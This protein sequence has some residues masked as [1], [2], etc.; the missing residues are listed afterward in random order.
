MFHSR[1]NKPDGA[2]F[3]QIASETH[4]VSPAVLE[5][6]INER[7]D[8]LVPAGFPCQ[9]PQKQ[10][11]SCAACAVG[12]ITRDIMVMIHSK[13]TSL[14]HRGQMCALDCDKWSKGADKDKHCARM[15]EARERGLEPIWVSHSHTLPRIVLPAQIC[16][17]VRYSN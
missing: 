3:N 13:T 14:S 8:W 15:S 16:T 17:F 1:F 2:S 12:R 5:N 4:I 9:Q 10:G 11:E 6:W 7:T